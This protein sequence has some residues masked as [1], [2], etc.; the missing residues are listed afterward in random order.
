MRGT[1]TIAPSVLLVAF[2]EVRRYS[3]S[4]F[5]MFLTT[6]LPLFLMA[7]LGAVFHVGLPTKLPIAVVDLDG[8]DLSRRI[9]RA[10]DATPDAA[11]AIAVPDLHRGKQLILQGKVHGLLFLPKYLE[12]DTLAGRR[13]EVVFFY[14]SQTLTNGNLV[15]RGVSNAV[16]TV[17]AGVRLALRTSQGEPVEIAEEQLQPIPVQVNPLFNP[18]LNYTFFLLAS[19]IPAILQIAVVTTAA[20]V[21]GLDIE[22]PH[23]LAVLRRLGGG[24]W[25]AMLGKIL[26]YSAIFLVV[27]GLSDLVLFGWFGMPLRGDRLI[28]VAGGCLFVIACQLVGVCVACIVRNAGTAISVGTLITAPAFGFMGIGFPRQGMN[29]FSY[30]WGDILPGTWYLML[31]IDQT[32]RGTPYDESLKPLFALMAVLL[33]YLASSMILLLTIRRGRHKDS[34]KIRQG[35]AT[36]GTA[37]GT[38]Q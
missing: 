33:T 31:R 38:T 10:V 6:A 3:R 27:L 16:P 1:G 26:P 19:L 34:G 23:R 21:A 29:S 7:L 18:T 15:L 30:Y 25:P 11:I 12:R 17:E 20:Y 2:R 37:A 28:L 4:P 13:P 36:A 35:S 8:S 5:L 22:T 9:M 32:V 24:L 14:N